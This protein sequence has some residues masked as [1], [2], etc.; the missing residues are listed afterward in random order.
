MQNED[1]QLVHLFPSTIGVY[2]NTAILQPVKNLFNE[3]DQYMSRSVDDIYTTIGVYSPGKCV[4]AVD[5]RGYEGGRLL[6]QFII[7]SVKRY[8]QQIQYYD[9]DVI[10]EN[11]WLNSMP[12]GT[13]SPNHFHYGYA[14]SGVYYVKCTSNNNKITFFDPK[15][16]ILYQPPRIKEYNNLNSDSWWIGI[17]EGDLVIFPSYLRHGVPHNNELEDRRSI[18]FDVSLLFTDESLIIK[19]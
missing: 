12:T 5:L 19:K 6:E 1:G 4:N 3:C 9:Y 17:N 16:A 2:S 13:T 15:S 10:V 14:F 8:L 18:A 7:S 11:M